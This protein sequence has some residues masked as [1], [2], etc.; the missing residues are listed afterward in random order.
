MRR[1]VTAMSVVAASVGW[2]VIA[3]KY[4]PDIAR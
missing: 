4:A 3:V 1:L 2:E